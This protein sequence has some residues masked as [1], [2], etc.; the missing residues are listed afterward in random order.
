M[1]KKIVLSYITLIAFVIL[2]ACSPKASAP[3]SPPPLPPIGGQET[4]RTE[5]KINVVTQQKLDSVIKVGKRAVE[6][7]NVV[8]QNR[9]LQTRLNLADRNTKNPVP[10]EAP[11]VTSIKLM[12]EKFAERINALPAE[13]KLVLL[14]EKALVETPP[15]TDEVFITMI[16][17]LNSSYQG[18]VRWLGQ[19]AYFENWY[20]DQDVRDIRGYYFFMKDPA[21]VE[22]LTRFST[23][24]E[25]TKT[26][27]IDWLV[28][29][30]HNALLTKA[31][32]LAELNHYIKSETVPNFH[33]RYLKLAKE[34]YDSF[35]TLKK[36]RSE[37][38]WNSDRTLLTQDFILPTLEKIAV[39]LKT[40][41]EEEWKMDG[42]QL[43]VQFIPKNGTA[44]FV[45]FEKGVTPNV[46]GETWNV[47]TM[48]PDYSLDDYNTQWT[49]RHEFGHILGFPDCYLEFYDRAKE[50]MIYY[51]IETD[52]L[53]CAWGGKLKPMHLEELKRVYK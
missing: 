13:M 39:W 36:V 15:V 33:K 24:D 30:C 21:A 23:L 26:K 42:F 29:M 32:C 47:I 1:H 14:E 18:A 28:G 27:Y 37:L 41:I 46:S 51:T 50:E 19:E 22:A 12:Q 3:P 20:A 52:N 7:L 8:N 45:K 5:Q 44:P 9:D 53:M 48:D 16:R 34:T 6:W 11:K 10:P 38:K 40:N 31:N 25:A 2:A 4:V 35:F 17:E 43:L 49:I